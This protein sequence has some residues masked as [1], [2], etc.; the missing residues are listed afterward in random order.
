MY[1]KFSQPFEKRYKDDLG[2][3]GILSLHICGRSNKIIEGMVTTGCE[4]LELDHHNDLDRSFG[5][6]A[7]RSCVFGNLDPSSVLNSDTP[8]SSKKSRAR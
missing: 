7:N 2:R 1:M 5:V 8:R 6:V 3:E 4:V